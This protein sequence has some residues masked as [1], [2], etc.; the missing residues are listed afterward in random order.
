MDDKKSTEILV[1]AIKRSP[2]I[3]ALQLTVLFVGRAIW[4]QK[5]HTSFV[6]AL[7]YLNSDI[8]A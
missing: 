7:L 5:H 2:V 6:S 4:Q 3:Y 8:V 1:N